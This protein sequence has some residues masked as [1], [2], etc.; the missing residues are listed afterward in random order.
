[1]N[2]NNLD[3]ITKNQI[4]QSLELFH[5]I[6][7]ESLVGVYLY[8]SALTG[9]L[10][11][12]SDIDLFVV[13][14][15]NMTIKEKQKLIKHLLAI[16]GIYKK[17]E[18]RPIEATFVNIHD[19]K[20]WC[21]PPKFDFQYGEWLRETFISGEIEPWPNKNMPDLAMLL[22]QLQLNNHL[23]FGEN[24]RTLLPPIPQADL[25]NSMQD[26]LQPLISNITDD[27]TNVLLT[28]ARIWNTLETNEIVS[29]SDAASFALSKLSKPYKHA[30][31]RTKSIYLGLEADNW[32]DMMIEAKQCCDV[33]SH[34]I[35]TNYKLRTIT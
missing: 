19:I 15:R 16:S 14:N 29:K 24:A 35:H 30:M 28:L 7:R 3:E 23:L 11:K 33:I 8:G 5:K 22:T 32:Q 25:F 21:Y 26:E 20:P 4:Q 1:M 2:S 6:L 18:K 34:I 31:E 13:A 27:T 9:G 17:E 12:Y 10:Q